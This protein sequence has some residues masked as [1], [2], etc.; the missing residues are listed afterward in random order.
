MIEVA[1]LQT[2]L[3]NMQKEGY[4]YSIY[5][6]GSYVSVSLTKE[7]SGKGK[8]MTQGSGESF[9]S[10]LDAAVAN[11]PT[12]PLDGTRWKQLR[13]EAPAPKGKD[14]DEIPF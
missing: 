4:T 13:L 7:T 5:G 14:D 9:L 10:A 1:M 2:A 8:V 11:F 6:N 12:H 3:S